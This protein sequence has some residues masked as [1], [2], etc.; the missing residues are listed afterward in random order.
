[1][2]TNYKNWTHFQQMMNHPWKRLKKE[3]LLSLMKRP[4]WIE[5]QP[6]LKVGDILWVHK[7]LTPRSIWS[8]GHVK[9]EP[10]GRDGT[11]RVVTVRSAYGYF[12]L[13]LS[14]L[15]RFFWFFKGKFC[16]S[17]YIYFFCYYMFQ[18]S[19]TRN[20]FHTKLEKKIKEL[21]YDLSK[22]FPKHVVDLSF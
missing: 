18:N 15:L 3:Y 4:K 12:S 21:F 13:P 1:M 20:Q 2:L 8:I 16:L 19:L 10:P 7:D 9:E 5:M 14:L 11:T 22:S 17:V 6:S